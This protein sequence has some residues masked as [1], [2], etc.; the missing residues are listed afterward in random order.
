MHAIET[1]LNVEFNVKLS[2]LS[3]LHNV[4]SRSSDPYPMIH[5]NHKAREPQISNPVNE[6]LSNS[7]VLELSII[8]YHC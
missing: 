7:P 1:Q 4:Y 8:G 6:L 5:V 2:P 3:F